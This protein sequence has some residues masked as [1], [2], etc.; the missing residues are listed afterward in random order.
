MTLNEVYRDIHSKLVLSGVNESSILFR[1]VTKT[2]NDSIRE[3]RNEYLR[4][5]NVGDIFSTTEV[6][7][8][9]D[10]SLEYPYLKSKQLSKVP[11]KDFPIE[12]VFLNATSY[13][14]KNQ[15]LDENQTFTKKDFATKGD[16]TYIALRNIEN[17]NTYNATVNP[18]KVK[19][20]YKN[21]GLTYRE[22]DKILDTTNDTYYRIE[23]DFVANFDTVLSSTVQVTEL[24]WKLFSTA[25]KNVVFYPLQR[26]NELRNFGKIDFSTGLSVDKD[27]LLATKNIK[28][29]IVTY[30]PEWEDIEDL[31]QQLDLPDY[32]IPAIK[33][34]AITILAA[35]LGIQ[36][37]LEQP[38][39]E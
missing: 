33:Y 25:Y 29:L 6:L 18:F 17:E 30:I 14:T 16:Y 3:I 28:K 32:F 22:G 4:A 36:V 11:L 37:N 1:D 34:R 20:Y 7:V 9:F 23:E 8:D 15:I 21:S 26:I 19:L 2:I 39:N 38:T 13:A 35:K 24:V 27:K 31:T 5:N 12:K 10:D